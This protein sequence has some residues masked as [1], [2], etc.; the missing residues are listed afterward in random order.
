MFESLNI[1]VV[2]YYSSRGKVHKV[3]KQFCFAHNYLSRT[4]FVSFRYIVLL[5]FA[6]KLNDKASCLT[7]KHPLVSLNLS[8]LNLCI[9]VQEEE[10]D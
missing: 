7:I 1:P 4:N 2:E 6:A 5:T 8:S 9:Q 3:S 10:I